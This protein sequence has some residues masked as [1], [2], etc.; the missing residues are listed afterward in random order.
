[1]SGPVLHLG[2]WNNKAETRTERDLHFEIFPWDLDQDMD[3]AAQRRDQT[4]QTSQK[5]RKKKKNPRPD[6]PGETQGQGT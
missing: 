6:Q 4:I 3:S 2:I 1:M 5:K